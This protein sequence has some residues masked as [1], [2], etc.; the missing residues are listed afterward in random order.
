MSNDAKKSGF[1]SS[2]YR[3]KNYEA[4]PH[5]KLIRDNDIKKYVWMLA[6]SSLRSGPI[7][8]Y[9]Y[10]QAGRNSPAQKLDGCGPLLRP[11]RS[12]ELR[13]IRHFYLA[14]FLKHLPPFFYHSFF[15][16]L[17]FWIASGFSSSHSQSPHREIQS[18]ITIRFLPITHALHPSFLPN[19]LLDQDVRFEAR[20]L[21]RAPNRH[22]QE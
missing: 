21:A 12:A 8:L 3:N 6:P 14:D 2:F 20:W 5:K 17:Y 9:I 18:S 7:L 1:F 16:L 11:G 19:E 15:T 4:F 10:L 22:G 13:E